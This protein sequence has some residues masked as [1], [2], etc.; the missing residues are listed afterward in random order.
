MILP[1]MA[2]PER[3]AAIAAARREKE[4]S[5]ATLRH[6]QSVERQIRQMADENHYAEKIARQII[7]GDHK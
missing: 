3:H 5:Q 6:A 4:H 1:W 2:K 7:W